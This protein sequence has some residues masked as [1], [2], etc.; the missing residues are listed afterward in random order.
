M[1][2]GQK[3]FTGIL[4]F[5]P[6]AAF[7][8]Y[9]ISFLG[10]FLN[11]IPEMDRNPNAED[12]IL[13]EVFNIIIFAIVLGIISLGVLVYFIILA[14]NNKVIDSTERLVWVLIFLFA[15]IVGYPIYWYMRVQRNQIL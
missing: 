7:M 13:P 6:L 5:L 1:T 4:A 8:A 11:I 12:Y 10:F 9:M 14:I 3:V 15:G 2:Q